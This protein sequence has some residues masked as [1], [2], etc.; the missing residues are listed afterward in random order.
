[1][2]KKLLKRKLFWFFV[3]LIPLLYV[4]YTSFFSPKTKNTKETT[5]T[6]KK[7][8]IKET[9][10]IAGTIEANEIATLRFQSSG[11][12]AWVG[13]KEGDTVKK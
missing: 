5:Y 6:V 3:I 4:G 13:V 7:E 9:L 12:L 11:L 8:T 10:S 1:M 2:I